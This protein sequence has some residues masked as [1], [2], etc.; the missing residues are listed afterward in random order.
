[1]LGI[2]GSN[3]IAG[4][5]DATRVRVVREGSPVAEREKEPL[6]IV[7]EA[8]L[9]RIRGRQVQNRQ[10]RRSAPAQRCGQRSF[11]RIPI[12]PL[13]KSDLPFHLF[14]IPHLL[15]CACRPPPPPLG[16]GLNSSSD[17]TCEIRSGQNPLNIRLAC[18]ILLGNDLDA[19]SCPAFGAP[20]FS[21]FYL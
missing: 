13:R 16:R 21:L 5:E 3:C 10:S 18:K 20:V 6:G 15:I 9:R 12:G 2:I 4:G 14:I 19:A 8:A 7:V 17:W 1:M 11:R